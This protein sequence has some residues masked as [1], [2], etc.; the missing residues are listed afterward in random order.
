M[1]KTI[2]KLVLFCC[3]FSIA[4]NMEAQILDLESTTDGMLMPRMTTIEREAI[5]NLSQSL[6]VYDTD[7]KSFWYYEDMM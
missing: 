7:T 1:M 6:L 4:S 2:Y 3:L 5:T